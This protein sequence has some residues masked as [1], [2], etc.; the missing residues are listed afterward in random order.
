MEASIELLAL[1]QAATKK[2]HYARFFHSDYAAC[3]SS[4]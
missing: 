4:R 3:L 2:S 1:D